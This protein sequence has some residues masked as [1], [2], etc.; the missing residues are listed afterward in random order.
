MNNFNI[1]FYSFVTFSDI[2]FYQCP[3]ITHCGLLWMRSIL[4]FLIHFTLINKTTRGHQTFFFMNLTAKRGRGEKYH[5]KVVIKAVNKKSKLSKK[6][7]Q[8]NKAS[9]SVLRW[10]F[11]LH[12]LFIRL[13]FPSSRVSFRSVCGHISVLFKNAH[14]NRPPIQS[15]LLS[16]PEAL[17]DLS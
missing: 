16:G 9:L 7:F 6:T 10:H 3:N 17:N 13:A 4:R 12:C 14:K 15:Y 5:Q 11:H 2:Y 8:L 1:F